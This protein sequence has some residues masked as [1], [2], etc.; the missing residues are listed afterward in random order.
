MWVA[1]RTRCYCDVCACV[2]GRPDGFCPGMWPVLA[3]DAAPGYIPGWAAGEGARSEEPG[4]QNQGDVP[5]RAC[6]RACGRAASGGCSPL[7]EVGV[8]PCTR[9]SCSASCAPSLTMRSQPRCARAL[10]AVMSGGR[11]GVGRMERPNRGATH[12]SSMPSPARWAARRRRG[13]PVHCRQA[14]REPVSFVGDAVGDAVG[15]TL[16]G[17]RQRAAIDYATQWRFRP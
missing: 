5:C 1:S 9:A 11:A 2:A 13:R 15:D 3:A 16:R 17:S 4:A 6:R 8:Q 7:Y 12:I 14:C 10:I